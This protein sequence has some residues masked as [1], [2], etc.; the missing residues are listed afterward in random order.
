MV[1]QDSAPICIRKTTLSLAP[2]CH[3]YLTSPR[4][5]TPA[6]P[7][8]T[9]TISALWFD[10]IWLASYCM[11]NT[12]TTPWKLV[13]Y[14]CPT[15]AR[16]LLPYVPTSSVLIRLR[17]DKPR[18]DMPCEPIRSRADMPTEPAL[19]P[20]CHRQVPAYDHEYCT[21]PIRTCQEDTDHDHEHCTVPYRPYYTAE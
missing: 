13:S 19:A 18:T 9:G 17:T 8:R 7:I 21:V 20:Y 4:T 11:T 14:Y 6:T 2:Y 5:D 16:T 1:R 10:L 3:L 15:G 12:N